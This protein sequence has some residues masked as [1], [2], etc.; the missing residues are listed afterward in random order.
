MTLNPGEIAPEFM[1]PDTEGISV[2]LSD[3]RGQPVVLYFYRSTRSQE[4]P[5][6]LNP[7]NE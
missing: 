1:L 3:F 7:G 5:R 4:K 6:I 2:S